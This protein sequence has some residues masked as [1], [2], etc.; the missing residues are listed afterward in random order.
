M[1]FTLAEWPLERLQTVPTACFNILVSDM[2]LIL[3]QRWWRK[4]LLARYQRKAKVLELQQDALRK[5]MDVLERRMRALDGLESR[6]ER[7]LGDQSRSSN[8]NQQSSA[9]SMK[10]SGGDDYHED[11]P[12]LGRREQEVTPSAGPRRLMQP[13]KLQSPVML[14]IDTASMGQKRDVISPAPSTLR[15]QDAIEAVEVSLVSLMRVV[16]T[17]FDRKVPSVGGKAPPVVLVATTQATIRRHL[18]DVHSNLLAAMQAHDSPDWTAIDHLDDPLPYSLGSLP[19]KRLMDDWAKGDA[20][21]IGDLTRWLA[22]ALNPDDCTDALPPLELT[23]LQ[24]MVMEGF[25]RLVVPTLRECRRG[26]RV[27]SKP[28]Q[29]SVLRL[30]VCNPM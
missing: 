27:Q 7:Q 10:R 30:D 15:Y 16:H 5:K 9:V 8:S 6:K 14:S 3:L 29:G 26:I 28:V 2:G 25:L 13:L 12:R 24:P 22:L 18:S 1:Q 19:W 17:A 23:C 11:K 4:H 21:K 20:D